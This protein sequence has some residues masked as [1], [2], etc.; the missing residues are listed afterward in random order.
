MPAPTTAA[1]VAFACCIAPLPSFPVL[2][3]CACAPA[4]AARDLCSSRP[5]AVRRLLCSQNPPFHPEHL[6]SQPT[7]GLLLP[8]SP[9]PLLP[10][11][12]LPRHRRAGP[13]AAGC[14]A[15]QGRHCGHSGSSCHGGQRIHRWGGCIATL[16][17]GAV[18]DVVVWEVWQ[19]LLRVGCP[20]FAPWRPAALVRP[21]CS[22]LQRCVA[23]LQ[24]WRR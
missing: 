22:P 16:V 11:L 20:L 14:Q 9:N 3:P 5:C 19:D 12:Q 7:L 23:M 8:P 10:L 6:A 2:L 21:S 24:A 1:C 4:N 15:S 13:R 18:A 17:Q